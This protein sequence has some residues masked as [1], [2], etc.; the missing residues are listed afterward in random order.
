MTFADLVVIA[1]DSNNSSKYSFRRESGQNFKATWSP[2]SS[3]SSMTQTV[4]WKYDTNTNKAVS[5]EFALVIRDGNGTITHMCWDGIGVIRLTNPD[6]SSRLLI[7][8]CY[9]HSTIS[10]KPSF[11]I[12]TSGTA[13]F[14]ITLGRGMD[15]RHDCGLYYSNFTIDDNYVYDGVVLGV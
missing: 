2:I 8:A 14:G 1:F 6:T 12:N 10:I 4:E 5:A 15:D 3:G 11:S 9:G 13:S 7:D